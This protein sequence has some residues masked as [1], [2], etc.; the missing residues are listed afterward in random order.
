MSPESQKPTNENEQTPAQKLDRYIASLSDRH[1]FDVMT[2]RISVL[3]VKR[4]PDSEHDE[5]WA[6]SG[7]EL[8]T[9]GIDKTGVQV[10]IVEKLL[11]PD[12]AG[13]ARK[14]VVLAEALAYSAEV[15]RSRA[16][17]V[18]LADRAF[19]VTG[20][21]NPSAI[22]PFNDPSSNAISGAEAAAFIAEV[23][24]SESRPEAAVDP[25]D[26]LSPEDRRDVLQYQTLN[27]E[28][29][30]AHREGRWLDSKDLKQAAFELSR[31]MSPAAH[32][33]RYR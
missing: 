19:A 22:E 6:D 25:L 24:Q 12:D 7:W 32:E 11:H 18:E 2:E 30:A 33:A 13:P 17:R 16:P 20:P 4:S 28:Q 29:E 8:Y 3:N 10:G 26:S 21:T 9:T 5:P 15:A 14:R 1:D 27:R 31:Q 23:R